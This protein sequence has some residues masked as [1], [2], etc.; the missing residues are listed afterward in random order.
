MEAPLVSV[1]MITYNHAPLI[2]KAIEGVLQQRTNFPFELVIGED[3][4]SDGT[5]EIVFDYQKKYPNVIHVVS[6]DTNVGMKKN[7]YRTAKACRGKYIAFCEGDDYWHHSKK[8]QIQ[9][10]YMEKHPECGMIYADCDKLHYSTG[11]IEKSVNI[12]KG[13]SFPRNADTEELIK[14]EGA[15]PWTCTVMIRRALAERVIEAD[16]FLHKSEKF[17]MGDTQLWAET[18]LL[19]NVSYMPENFATHCVLEESVSRSKDKKK[20]LK[21]RKS[22]AE[23]QLYLCDKHR[24]SDDLRK[25]GEA[26]WHNSTLCLAFHVRDADM[27]KEVKNKKKTFTAKEWL[28]YLGARIA[29]IYYFNIIAARFSNLV[30]SRIEQK[31]KNW[32]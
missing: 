24:L 1:K 15:L 23:M 4:S 21:F 9:V 3:C 25:K 8:L 7:A 2:T 13:Y 17:L 11:R 16:Y 10:D 28:W 14:G 20:L 27:A 26:L 6:S 32:L 18:S 29:V 30:S 19:A 31:Q 22:V 12:G 5:R